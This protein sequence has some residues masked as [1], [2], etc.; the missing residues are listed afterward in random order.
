MTARM[1][2]VLEQAAKQD[3]RRVWDGP[4]K[5]PWPAAASTLAALVR[6]G[7]LERSERLT[8]HQQR[9][10][11]WEITEE[12]KAALRGPERI[13]EERP[14]FMAHGAIRYRVLSN[15]RWTVV[16]ED[17]DGSYVDGD[18][19][20]DPRRR[21]DHLEV[22]GQASLKWRRKAEVDRTAAQDPKIAARRIS[23]ALRAA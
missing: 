7:L 4:G 1:R 5:P 19:T 12:G 3:L 10:V 21:F 14:T 20:Q 16:E 15:N 13:A 6:H 18:Y 23:R 11:L 17:E 22:A 2:A 9:V 8:R